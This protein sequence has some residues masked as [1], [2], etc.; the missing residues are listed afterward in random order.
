MLTRLEEHAEL[1]G[2]SALEA[3][4]RI[5]YEFDKMLKK[6][7]SG[8]MRRSTDQIQFHRLMRGAIARKAFGPVFKENEAEIIKYHNLETTRNIVLYT[9]PRR[10]GKTLSASH[11]VAV[12]LAQ[13]PSA[14]IVVIAPSSRQSG[15]KSGFMGAVEKALQFHKVPYE[16]ASETLTITIGGNVR[17]FSSFSSRA[18][19]K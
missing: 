2:L 16:R 1:S 5:M 11:L 7:D 13:I 10:G 14:E 9:L 4:N 15:S 17:K 8:S 12:Y 6:M 3:G 18:G 19:N